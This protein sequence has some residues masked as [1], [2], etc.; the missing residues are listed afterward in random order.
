MQITVDRL[1]HVMRLTGHA[2]SSRGSEPETHL[3]FKEGFAVS[4][5]RQLAIAVEVPELREDDSFSLPPKMLEETLQ[6]LPG[7]TILEITPD[8]MITLTAPGFNHQRPG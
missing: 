5:N 8:N 6:F 1:R 7:N 4:N 3:L 2:V